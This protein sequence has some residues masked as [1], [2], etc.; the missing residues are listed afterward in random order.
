[1]STIDIREIAPLRYQRTCAKLL[2]PAPKI[3]KVCV[4]ESTRLLVLSMED[5]LDPNP[6]FLLDDLPRRAFYLK[7]LERLV[8]STA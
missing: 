1:M 7:L 6:S 2:L 3:G 4:R 8:R 5:N